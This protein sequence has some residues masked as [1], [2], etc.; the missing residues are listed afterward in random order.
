MFLQIIFNIKFQL[1]I[2]CKLS[3]VVMESFLKLLFKIVVL[4]VA[5][6]GFQFGNVKGL[7]P[8]CQHP[9][10][11]CQPVFCDNPPCCQPLISN[12]NK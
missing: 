8:C 10:V 1:I 11:E 7:P 5:M 6:V 3:F 2:F 9:D 12:T 4:I